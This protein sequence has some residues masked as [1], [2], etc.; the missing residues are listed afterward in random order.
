MYVGALVEVGKANDVFF[1]PQHPYTQFLVAANPEPDP[2][3]NAAAP[4]PRSRTPQTPSYTLRQEWFG[5]ISGR[6]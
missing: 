3:P 1:D 2:E 5:G 4:S 6:D